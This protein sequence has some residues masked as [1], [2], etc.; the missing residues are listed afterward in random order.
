MLI[1]IYS[2]VCISFHTAHLNQKK[3]KLEN[4]SLPTSVTPKR[5][6]IKSITLHMSNIT[7]AIKL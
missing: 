3:R 7:E 4:V 1:E 5:I 2:N 6:E